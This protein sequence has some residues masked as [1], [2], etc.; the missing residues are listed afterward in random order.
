MNVGDNFYSPP[1][2][3][4][5]YN[6]LA[7]FCVATSVQGQSMSRFRNYC[8]TLNFTASAEPFVFTEADVSSPITYLCFQEEVGGAEGTHHLQ[9]YLELDRAMTIAAV[10][11][12]PPFR[13]LHADGYSFTLLPRRGTQAQAIAYC[14]KEDDTSI[15]GSFTEIGAP[16][17]QGARSDLVAVRDAVNAKRSREDLWEDHFPTMV[18]YHKAIT[19]YTRIRTRPR[20]WKTVVFFL[21]GPPGT[22]K[23]RTATTLCSYL[24]STLGESRYYVFPEK[25]TGFWCDDYDRQ[26]VAFLDEMD[27]N[28]MTPT[29]FN[30]LA[31]RY[32]C[33]VPAHGTAGHQFLAKYLVVCSNYLPKY[34]WRQRSKVQTE[35]VMRRLDV[36]IPFLR[37]PP[38]LQRH[39]P[40]PGPPTGVVHGPQGFFTHLPPPLGI[41]ENPEFPWVDFEP[42]DN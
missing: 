34:W 5:A 35:Q 1:A 19:E 31:D 15:P 3:E 4:L 23:T 36:V 7:H 8:F 41:S 20:S 42:L 21:V 40:P 18:R 32:E 9:G 16:K 39:A 37:G 22:G 28:R 13:D 6:Y 12:L 33:V 38:D 25:R 30:S 29:Q 14:S 27:G 10:L 24:A 11:A 2:S 17:A 26:G